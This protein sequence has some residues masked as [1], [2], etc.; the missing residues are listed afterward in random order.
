MTDRD[1]YVWECL[2]KSF[3]FHRDSVALQE[4]AAAPAWLLD[5]KNIV[6]DPT[7]LERAACLFWQQHQNLEEVQI[8]G[9]E[10]SAISLVAAIV[11]EGHRN[12]K[13]VN[14]FYVRKSRKRE[15]LRKQVE[16]K[17]TT[18]PIIL[19]DDIIN[20]GRSFEKQIAVLEALGLQ[21]TE[22][23]ALVHFQSLETYAEI[24]P[25]T[26]FTA[27]FALTDFGIPFGTK[28]SAS[29]LALVPK[30]YVSSKRPSYDLVLPTA[31][32]CVSGDTV[33]WVS[34]EG[35]LFA[36][37]QEDFRVRWRFSLGLFL[38]QYARAPLVI[39]GEYLLCQTTTGILYVFNRVTGS[40]Y[41]RLS[42]GEQLLL[43]PL[44]LKNN[45]VAVCAHEGTY[46]SIIVVNLAMRE[47]I[48]TQRTKSQVLTDG[49][50]VPEGFLFTDT[51]GTFY[52]GDSRGMTKT[53]RTNQTLSGGGLAFDAA[54]EKIYFLNSDGA[55]MVAA[56]PKMRP[57]K[58]ASATSVSFSVPCI[59]DDLAYFSSLDHSVYAVDKNTGLVSWTYQ[60]RGRIFA[61]PIVHEGRVFIGSN[62]GCLYVLDAIKGSLL[63]R[64]QTAERIT[65]PVTVSG[66]SILVQ[67]YGGSLY[68]FE[69]VANKES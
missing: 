55:L 19:V 32:P 12:G 4:D 45:C 58:L 33:Y 36:L 64:Y 2:R 40:L 66:E 50:I 7:F 1:E 6:L 51:G 63:A 48:W 43:R 61:S 18:A 37:A 65:G 13:K 29:A 10:T 68:R 17:L 27:A 26:L 46:S 8:G 11:L 35:Q 52:V 41:W 22:C 60:T 31:A 16:G 24:S 9:M 38:R 57:Q 30:A 56:R 28:T 67:G 34:D 54:T 47:K 5:I 3:V 39:V 15:G 62:D 14:G 53:F 20:K 25:T 23:F 44:I 69:L 42:L 21:V 49:C 59:A